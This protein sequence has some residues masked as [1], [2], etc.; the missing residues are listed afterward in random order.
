MIAADGAIVGVGIDTPSLDPG[1]NKV[2]PAHQALFRSN[3]FGV[4][5]VGDMSRVPATGATILTLPMKIGGGIGG[6][7]RVLVR[8]P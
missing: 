4:E 1:N 6:P 2:V 8:L 3:I 7:C 5:H